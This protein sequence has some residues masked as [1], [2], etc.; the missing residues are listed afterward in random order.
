MNWMKQL[1]MTLRRKL[2]P[3]VACLAT[4]AL[5]TNFA[6][7]DNADVANGLYVNS[8]GSPILALIRS[9]NSTIDIEIYTMGDPSV[10]AE[11]HNALG[12]NVRLRIVKD[13]QPVGKECHVFEA[14]SDSDSE[15][16]ANQKK[17]VDEVRASRDGVYVPF[18][19]AELCGGG[20]T[21]CFQHGKMVLVDSR[22]ALISTGNFDP[23]NL[24]DLDAGPAQ[25]NRDYSVVTDDSDVVATLSDIF[26]HDAAGKS[27]DL[28]SLITPAA[29]K[30]LT[31]SPLSEEPLVNFI[32]S[33]RQSIRVENQYLKADGINQALETAAHNG[34]NV[35]VVV[36]SACAFGRPK[37][38]EVGQITSTFTDFDNAGI[39]SKMFTARDLI[40]GRKGYMHAKALIVDDSHAWVG[41]VNGSDMSLSNN[42]EFGLFIDNPTWVA[43]LRQ[44][45]DHDYS[46]DGSET[47][48]DSLSCAENKGTRHIRT[49]SKN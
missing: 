20:V 16:C 39:K 14:V 29:A 17:F 6:F 8:E 28:A 2:A 49:A 25:C 44:T 42:R 12:R 46:A 43:K 1:P 15:E 7:A 41:S 13:G 4:V 36:A 23:S 40:N 38:S 35:T 32:K 19:K 33:A 48:G 3:F 30:K 47:W 5:I 27:Y 11:L 45:V 37:P 34:I 24:C 21:H 9:A 18:N 10:L 31:V 26:E 22:K